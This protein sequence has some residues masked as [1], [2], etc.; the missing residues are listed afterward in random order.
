MKSYYKFRTEYRPLGISMDEDA[1]G[2][3]KLLNGT[4]LLDAEFFRNI[5]KELAGM[6]C[7]IKVINI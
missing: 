2:Y 5:P 6:S 4:K 3:F 1:C 7:P